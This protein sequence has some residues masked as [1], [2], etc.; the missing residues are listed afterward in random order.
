MAGNSGELPQLE[1]CWPWSWWKRP[2]PRSSLWVVSTRRCQARSLA[3]DGRALTSLVNSKT[4]SAVSHP[5]Q[6]LQLVQHTNY[7]RLWATRCCLRRQSHVRGDVLHMR[8]HWVK[9][10]PSRSTEWTRIRAETPEVEG[11]SPSENL[12]L[13]HCSH[14]RLILRP[15]M[16]PQRG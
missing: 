11:V 4:A 7:V 2:W 8:G 16:G 13:G 14:N 1:R 12:P 6:S 9:L 10:L 15:E 5:G 3:R